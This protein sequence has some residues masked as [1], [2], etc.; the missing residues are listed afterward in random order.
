MTLSDNAAKAT[1]DIPVI[2]AYLLNEEGM[3]SAHSYN[4]DQLP[5]TITHSPSQYVNLTFA[6]RFNAGALSYT[7][8]G[9]VEGLGYVQCS[10]NYTI[11]AGSYDILYSSAPISTTIS[12]TTSTTSTS[13]S[14]SSSTTTAV[15]HNPHNISIHE[16]VEV[17]ISKPAEIIL[18]NG[19]IILGIST[20]ST[21][22]SIANVTVSIINAGSSPQNYTRLT[23]FY[24]NASSAV[25]ISINATAKY[26]CSMNPGN[27]SPFYLNN[28]T[29][30][31]ISHSVNQSSCQM[32]F[33]ILNMHEAGLF[34]SNVTATTTAVSTLT[35]SIRVSSH[36]ITKTQSRAV[37]IL[38]AIAALAAG[39][40]LVLLLLR[41]L[42]GKLK[43]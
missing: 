43:P 14:A 13:S 33:A 12:S 4:Q 7:Y 10:R 30:H 38:Y 27:V 3:I 6:C 29:W 31:E 24:V 9:D 19:S 11:I 42:K 15:Q 28:F 5:V 36:N 1:S 41:F 16:S 32:T 35:T 37:L 17:Y 40:V 26:P 25:N 23:A 39:I 8:T 2:W 20:N 34:V 21:T 18:E 22:P